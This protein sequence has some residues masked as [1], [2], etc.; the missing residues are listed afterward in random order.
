MKYIPKKGD[1]FKWCDEEYICIESKDFSGVVNLKGENYYER[2]F[3][4]N[5]GNEPQI[6]IREVTQE[7]YATLFGKL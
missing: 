6:F 2:G 3:I 1:V 7:E 4:W 5:Y